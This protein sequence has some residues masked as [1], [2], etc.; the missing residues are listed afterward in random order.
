MI[1]QIVILSKLGA[2]QISSVETGLGH[3][4]PSLLSIEPVSVNLLSEGKLVLQDQIHINHVIRNTLKKSIEQLKCVILESITPEEYTLQISKPA[5]DIVFRNGHKTLKELQSD[6]SI[7]ML[8]ADKGR[9]TV[10]L[11]GQNYL[12]K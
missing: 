1:Y 6:T 12:E 10:I 5:N 8:P 11:N 4:E 7:V 2:H 3:P 9:S